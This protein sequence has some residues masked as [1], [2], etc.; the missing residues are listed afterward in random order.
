MTFI[1]PL[2]LGGLV[3]VGI[4]II[5]H[6]VMRQTPKRL[7]FPAIRFLRQKQRSNQRR[8]LLRHLLLLLLRMALIA[9]LCLALVR[10]RLAGSSLGMAFTAGR[11]VNA[12]FLIDTS[13]SMEY[14]VA[15]K[16]WLDEARRRALELFEEIPDG[17]RIAVLDSSET[18][19]EWSPSVGLA[20]ERIAG[21]RLRHA[22]GSLAP[23][24]E[25]AYRLFK[26]V[27]QEPDASSEAFPKVLYIF[28]DRT[29]A[30]WDEGRV[31]TLQPPPE[32]SVAFVDVGTEGATDLAITAIQAEPATV[33]PGQTVRLQV[34]LQATGDNFE[35]G[36]NCCIDRESNGQSLPVKLQAGESKVFTFERRTAPH[37]SKGKGTEILAEG[38]HQAEIH[39]ASSDALAFD[40]TAFL[41]FRVQE[42]RRVLVLADDPSDAAAWKKILDPGFQV[43]IRRTAE[44]DTIDFKPYQV[45]CLVDVAKPQPA[46][47]ARLQPYVKAGGGLAVVPGGED[48]KPEA[49]AYSDDHFLPGRLLQWYTPEKA[50]QFWHE[51]ERAPQL[52]LGHPILAPFHRWRALGDVDFLINEASKPQAYRFWKVAPPE[53]QSEVVLAHYTDG[54]GTPGLPA[55][56]ARTVDAGRV[57]LF[58]TP[59]DRH[60]LAGDR[61]GRETNNYFEMSSFGFVLANLGVGYLA[62]DTEEVNPNYQ[63]G[64]Q[65]PVT[66][67]PRKRYTLVGPGITGSDADLSPLSDQKDLRITQAIVPGN[68][69]ILDEKTGQHLADFSTMPY[70]DECQLDRVPVEQIEAVLGQGSVVPVGAGTIC[71]NP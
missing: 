63:A 26:K 5:I 33:R 60:K 64:Q 23:Q 13:Y 34:T 18:D 22:G 10:P 20:R 35:T 57:L 30:C 55:L 3:L 54:K 6:L 44:A 28:S 59:F 4:P 65:I 51:L 52:L 29:R 68:F 27:D 39:L 9:V 43:E 37:G 50:Q 40:N 12:V 16:T 1:H 56:L 14:T 69:W 70:P 42:G 61:E 17:S 46:L 19:G 47:W 53:G 67:P 45:V 38:L 21:L 15:G 49:T 8:L 41:T 24:I 32:V 48:R 25:T 36:V 7:L 66:L 71:S 58:T 31:R 2:L 62:G 11:P